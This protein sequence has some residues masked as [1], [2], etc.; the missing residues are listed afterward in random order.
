MCVHYERICHISH[1]EYETHA[2]LLSCFYGGGGGR[3]KGWGL[4]KLLKMVDV[5]NP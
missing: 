3:V 2:G 5:D 1:I 4:M